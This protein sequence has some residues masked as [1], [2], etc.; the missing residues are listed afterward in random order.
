MQRATI[1]VRLKLL[2]E[3]GR[4]SVGVNGLDKDGIVHGFDLQITHGLDADKASTLGR[5]CAS[6]R[7]FRYLPP[8]S[9]ALRRGHPSEGENYS[10]QLPRSI[11]ARVSERRKVRR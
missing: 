8:P 10:V 9:H 7:V 6:R 1:H 2:N 4:D 5:K 3:T 11:N